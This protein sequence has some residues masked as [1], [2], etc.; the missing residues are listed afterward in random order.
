MALMFAVASVSAQDQDRD[1][2]RLQDHLLLKDGKM[3][4]ITDQDQTELKE[5]QIFVIF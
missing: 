2:I 1:Q 5:Q 4:R 3:Y